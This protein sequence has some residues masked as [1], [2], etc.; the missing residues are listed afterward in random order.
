MTKKYVRVGFTAAQKTE[1]WVV[2]IIFNNMHKMAARRTNEVDWARA[3]KAFVEY[4]QP[5]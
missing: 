4:I 2:Q 1:L 5:H 3:G